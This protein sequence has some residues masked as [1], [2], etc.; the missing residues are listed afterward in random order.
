MSVWHSPRLEP[1]IEGSRKYGNVVDRLE[2]S[3]IV[4][5]LESLLRI[6]IVSLYTTIQNWVVI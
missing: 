2:I 1:S 5:A 4:K 3:E 6:Q